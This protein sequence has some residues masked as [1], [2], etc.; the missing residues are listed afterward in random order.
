MTTFALLPWISI[1][2]PSLEEP[3]GDKHYDLEQREL[4]GF[5][6]CPAK[7]GTHTYARGRFSRSSWPKSW[8]R[9]P[10]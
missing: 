1:R 9:R 8:P 3:A 7:D 10:R 5:P 6:R 2:D 4:Q